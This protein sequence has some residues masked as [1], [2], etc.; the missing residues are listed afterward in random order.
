LALTISGPSDITLWKLLCRQFRGRTEES[1]E[2]AAAA[3]AAAEEEE[4]EEEERRIVA[5]LLNVI[6]VAEVELVLER[7]PSVAIACDSLR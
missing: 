4:E 2:S 5:G 7:T 1:D 3:A 6:Q